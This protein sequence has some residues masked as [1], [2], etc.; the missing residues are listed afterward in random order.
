[1]ARTRGERNFCRAKKQSAKERLNDSGSARKINIHE[2]SA[3]IY[4]WVTRVTKTTKEDVTGCD[5]VYIN[6][7]NNT[8]TCIGGNTRN[9]STYLLIYETEISGNSQQYI[10]IYLLFQKLFKSVSEM[11]WNLTSKV[12]LNYALGDVKIL[13]PDTW[14]GI[15]TEPETLTAT[16]NMIIDSPNPEYGHAPYTKHGGECGQIGEYVHLT[17][18]FLNQALAGHTRWGKAGIQCSRTF[19]FMM[20]LNYN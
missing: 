9:N 14:E 5:C 19:T 12:N 11:I 3:D 18:T 8:T 17:G 7:N 15:A 1:M 2:A 6:N 16:P 4:S 13:I 20:K 10:Y